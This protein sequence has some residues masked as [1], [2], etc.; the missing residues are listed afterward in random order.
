MD[1]G[2][3]PDR[4]HAVRSREEALFRTA[5]SGSRCLLNDHLGGRDFD[6]HL[7]G[8][9]LNALGMISAQYVFNRW[10]FLNIKNTGMTTTKNGIMIVLINIPNRNREPG[11]VFLAKI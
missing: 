2:Y 10:K 7:R 4:L 1:A 6:N 3:D 8:W 9:A 5:G 11:N